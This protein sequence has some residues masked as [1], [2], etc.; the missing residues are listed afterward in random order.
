MDAA[1]A[2]F[3]VIDETK[4]PAMAPSSTFK[5]RVYTAYGAFIDS[6]TA[7]FLLPAWK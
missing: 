3:T 7:P 4:P 2:R 6:L 5:G 1:S